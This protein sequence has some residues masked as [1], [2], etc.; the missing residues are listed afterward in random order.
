[1]AGN[2]AAGVAAGNPD[3]RRITPHATLLPAAPAG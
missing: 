2:V 3:Q 1:M